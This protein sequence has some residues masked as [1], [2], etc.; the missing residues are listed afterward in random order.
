MADRLTPRRKLL[1]CLGKFGVREH[2]RKGTGHRA[3][4]GTVDGKPMSY[5]LS[6]HGDNENIDPSIIKSIRRR[7]RLMPEDGVSDRKFYGKR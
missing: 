3:L 5:S 7:F 2:T 6:F 1:K 4:R